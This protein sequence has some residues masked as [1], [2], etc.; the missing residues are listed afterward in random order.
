MLQIRAA[1]LAMAVRNVVGSKTP[2]DSQPPEEEGS[3]DNSVEEGE[4]KLCAMFVS[5][6]S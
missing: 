6:H 2:L 5:R 4:S 3:G 1:A